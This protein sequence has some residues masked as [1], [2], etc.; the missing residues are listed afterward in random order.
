M[1]SNWVRIDA[2]A[3]AMVKEEK[4]RRGMLQEALVSEII[5]KALKKHKQ[6]K[7]GGNGE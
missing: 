4:K 5:K 1:K 3:M 2:E 7:G 6:I